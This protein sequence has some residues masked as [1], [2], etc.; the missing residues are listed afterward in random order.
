MGIP[1]EIPTCPVQCRL[2][3]CLP[4][5]ASPP[6]VACFACVQVSRDCQEV[7]PSVGRELTGL[8]Y[9]EPDSP[10]LVSLVPAAEI[11]APPCILLLCGGFGW[12]LC[13]CCLPPLLLFFS[14]LFCLFAPVHLPG[15]PQIGKSSLVR[16]PTRP[17]HLSAPSH[18]FAH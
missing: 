8:L 2:H 6:P 12:S 5:F 14:H 9:M 17:L 13:A 10:L 3:A 1:G 11:G 7:E 15:T 16:E 18:G 4:G